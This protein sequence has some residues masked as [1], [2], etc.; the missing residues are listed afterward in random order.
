MAHKIA[1]PTARTSGIPGPS[2][3]NYTPGTPGHFTEGDPVT[4]EPATVVTM[5][6]L[7]MVQDEIQNVVEHAGLDLANPN[8]PDNTQLRQAI[9]ILS[10]WNLPVRAV[11]NYGN[12][13]PQGDHDASTDR[14]RVIPC[15]ASLGDLRILLPAAASAGNGF[16]IA[17]VKTDASINNVSIIPHGSDQVQGTNQAF[18]LVT[19]DQSVLLASDGVG[20]WQVIAN[21]QTPP[22]PV[23]S[24]ARENIVLNS[25]RI[26]VNGELSRQGMVDGISDE[27]EDSLGIDQGVSTNANVRDGAILPRS[28]MVTPFEISDWT[29]SKV[30]LYQLSSGRVHA[31]GEVGGHREFSQVIYSASNFSGDFEILFRIPEGAPAS[32]GTRS[33]RAAVA[34]ANASVAQQ[35]TTNMWSNNYISLPSGAAL[36]GTMYTTVP[37]DHTIYAYK[38]SIMTGVAPGQDLGAV[39]DGEIFS[40]CRQN[41]ALSILRGDNIVY[42]QPGIDNDD[43][44]LLIGMAIYSGLTYTID[45]I[46]TREIGPV[47]NINAISNSITAEQNAL[48]GTGFF[49]VEAK[50]AAIVNTDFTGYLS[51]DDGQNWQALT[52]ARIAEFGDQIMYRGTTQFVTA[53]RDMRIRFTTANSKDI[54]LHAWSHIW[55]D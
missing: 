4:G 10:R 36:L 51:N 38:N 1:H 47:A 8:D 34:V 53:G 19:K 20:G 45:Q 35:I 54:V 37:G 48:T 24:W 17:V 46:S 52:L 18:S 40:I 29:G 42:T 6:W 9:P 26:A 11:V 23:D 41:G 14:G 28:L 7:N 5:D 50:E 49:L 15:D 13:N 16:D 30:N 27:F 31:P 33:Y 22:E 43:K 25:W 2:E 44:T 3:L 55:G 39:S 12:T 21:T 32:A